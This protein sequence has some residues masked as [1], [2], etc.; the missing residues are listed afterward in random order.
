MPHLSPR[1]ENTCEPKDAVTAPAGLAQT[2]ST[3]LMVRRPAG[4]GRPDLAMLQ[5]GALLVDRLLRTFGPVAERRLGSAC[6]QALLFAME[7][8]TNARLAPH[9]LPPI[10][11][12]CS[13]L[14]SVVRRGQNWAIWDPQQ[15]D[16]WQYVPGGWAALS[17]VLPQ[18]RAGCL[19]LLKLPCRLSKLHM[20]A[21]AAASAPL[22]EGSVLR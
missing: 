4:A 21:A 5:R 20:N 1:F 11:A 3:Y 19:K 10:R 16:V 18:V 6:A 14:E 15:P 2:Q 17:D 12:A 9:P 22:S 7:H 8:A 13:T